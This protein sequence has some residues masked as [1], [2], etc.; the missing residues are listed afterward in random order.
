MLEPFAAQIRAF[1]AHRS[2]VSVRK[3]EGDGLARDIFRA[4]GPAG[5]IFN[6]SKSN[7]LAT[8]LIGKRFLQLGA[9]NVPPL[10]EAVAPRLVVANAVDNNVVPQIDALVEGLAVAPNPPNNVVLPVGPVNNV[11]LPVGPVLGPVVPADGVN[12][13]ALPGVEAP[14][15]GAVV[16]AAAAPPVVPHPVLDPEVLRGML[17]NI[18]TEE[19]SSVLRVAR[20]VSLASSHVSQPAVVSLATND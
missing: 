18:I 11:V 4:L 1:S 5:T 17:R 8:V 12:N 19:L 13:D 20:G 9:M 6:D 2:Y 16:P 15:L 7:I 14:V 3:T 10:M